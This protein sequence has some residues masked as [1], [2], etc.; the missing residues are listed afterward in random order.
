MVVQE[1][2]LPSSVTLKDICERREA[3]VLQPNELEGHRLPR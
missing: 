3:A 1:I 2:T